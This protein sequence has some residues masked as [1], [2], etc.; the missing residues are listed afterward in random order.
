MKIDPKRYPR[1]RAHL[2]SRDGAAPLDGSEPLALYK[3][4]W[5]FV[6]EAAM[7]EEERALIVRLVA[8]HGGGVFMP[9]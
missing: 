7:T 5:R 6:D 4:N 9:N 8:D 3:R 1:L 2:W